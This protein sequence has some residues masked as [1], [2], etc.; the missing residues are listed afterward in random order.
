MGYFDNLGSGLGNMFGGGGYDDMTDAYNNIASQASGY[1]QN[2]NNQSAPYIQAG[3]G[4]IPN[5]QNW[6]SSMQDPSKYMANA[7]AGYQESPYAKYMK[8][9]TLNQL[10]SQQAMTGQLGGGGGMMDMASAANDI[11]SNDVNQYLDRYN[12]INNA[13]GAG[14]SNLMDFGQ[15]GIGQEDDF[16]SKMMDALSNAEGNSAQSQF[17]GSQAASGLLS[18]LGSLLGNIL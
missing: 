1:I 15:R 3:T 14:T 12:Q 8:Q 16:I 9:Q 10:G 5:Y 6:L 7:M 2:Q 13:Y 4:A 17:G 11:D 18:S